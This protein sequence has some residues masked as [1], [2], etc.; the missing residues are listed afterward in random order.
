MTLP[1][2]PL[3][4]SLDALL[5]DTKQR[6]E[7]LFADQMAGGRAPRA[8]TAH[9]RSAEPTSGR[10]E[11]Q[12]QS[13]PP[14]ADT[15]VPAPAQKAD[16]AQSP[17][18]SSGPVD[19][20]LVNQVSAALAGIRSE[21][22]T[23]LDR[24]APQVSPAT[25]M[26]MDTGGRLI[27][28]ERGGFLAHL[29]GSGAVHITNGDVLLLGDPVGSGGVTASLGEIAVI[30]P[31]EHQGS[32]IGYVSLHGR[33]DDARGAGPGLP[34]GLRIPP[35]K[36]YNGGTL[37][38]CAL[39]LILANGPKPDA[40]RA[41]LM[42]LIAACH[43]GGARVAALV[44]RLGSEP[45]HKTA[46]AAL[47]HARDTMATLIRD[48]LPE[49]PQGF[50]DVIDDDGLGNG[51]FQ[52]RLTVW[53]E[54]SH[55]YADWTGTSPQAPGPV[56]LPLHIGRAKALIGACICRV[57]GAG[58]LANDG[59]D[60]LIHVRIP[61]GSLLNP[62]AGARKGQNAVTLARVQDMLD[63]AINRHVP[64]RLS[65]ACGGAAAFTFSSDGI[66]LCEVIVGGGAATP[67]ADG[68]DGALI[69]TETGQP[70]EEIEA[71]YPVLIETFASLPGSGGAGLHRGGNGT[72]RVFRFLKPGQVTL[73]DDRHTSRPW[74]VNGGQAGANAAA[75]LIRAEGAREPL[76]ATTDAL[77]VEPGDRLVV[78]TAGGGGA[79]D[80]VRRD[81]GQ[82]L[83]DVVTGQLTAEGAKTYGVVIEDGRIDHR[84]TDSLREGLARER[85]RPALFDR[86]NG[87]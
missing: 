32:Q 47:D 12:S 14:A 82:V 84:A 21:I 76:P 18:Q 85:T 51:P 60:D 68:A 63:A 40:R 75:W 3:P 44:G 72:E 71:D 86:G 34:G 16:T 9:D 19:A 8:A 23:A 31:V 28:G 70:I 52:L 33:L 53:R 27:S 56:N 30:C 67:D 6:F 11:R 36:V 25:A 74:G 46:A 58:P 37:N 35:I 4:Q 64:D 43:H 29:L 80:P 78:R 24:A 7:D 50:D 17:S 39:D 20:V 83:H 81:L 62:D 57:S 79:G 15:P 87:A 41:Q 10:E 59:F 49:E 73:H 61:K 77:Q 42:A 26:I 2:K 55:A 1:P 69:L 13:V 65:A 48:T 54:G 22:E 45:F 38:Q 5:S 66:E